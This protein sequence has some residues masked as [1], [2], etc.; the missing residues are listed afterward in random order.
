MDPLVPVLMG[1]IHGDRERHERDAEE[2]DQ[3]SQDFAQKTH[4][5]FSIR[6]PAQGFKLLRHWEL[7]PVALSVEYS[8]RRK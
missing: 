6:V 3:D 4:S 2:K 5:C 1:G 7:A 8:Y